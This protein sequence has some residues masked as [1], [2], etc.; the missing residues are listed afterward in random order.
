MAGNLDDVSGDIAGWASEY[1][2]VREVRFGSWGDPAAIPR[3]VFLEMAKFA[4]KWTGYTHQWRRFRGLRFWLMASVDTLV[5]RDHAR[6]L[7]FRTFRVTKDPEQTKGETQCPA[8]RPGLEVTCR[9]CILCNGVQESDEVHRRA[10]ITAPAHGR[11]AA[12]FT[13]V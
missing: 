6:R 10:D 3:P 5:E 13:G 4:V 9:D 1:F 8:T 2:S 7:G 11:S 12:R